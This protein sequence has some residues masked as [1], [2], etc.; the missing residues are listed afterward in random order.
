MAINVAREPRKTEFWKAN[1]P[2][3]VGPGIYDKENKSQFDAGR[4]A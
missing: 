2:G 1:T 3:N 4:G